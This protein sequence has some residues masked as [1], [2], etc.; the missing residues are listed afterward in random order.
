[1][2]VEAMSESSSKALTLVRRRSAAA[3]P[4]LPIILEYQWPSAAVVNA[5]IPRS[6][7][8]MTW[9]IGSMVAALFT[10]MALIPVDQVVS[11]TGMVV[12]VS[13]TLLV[14]PLETSIVRSIDVREG[15]FVH[16]GDVLAHLDPTFASADY[17]ALA[18]LDTSL[19]AEVA[20]LRAEAGN[21]PFTYSGADPHWQ[22]QEAIYGHRRAEYDLKLDNYRHKLDEL[23]SAISRADADAEGYRE[24]L[25]VAQTI[26]K[27]RK[28]LESE[29]VGSRLNTL[30][31]TDSRAEMTRSLATA[32]KT[33]ESAKREL[34]ALVSERDGFI[35]TWNGDVAQKISDVSQKLN[36]VS[37]QLTKAKL[38]RQLVEL[39][40]ERDATV[41]SVAKVSIGSVLQSGQQLFTL[42][43]E[44]AVLEVEAN[45][46]GHDNGFVHMADPVAIK[47][48][49][50]PYARFGM[51]EG[52]VR[53]ISADSFTAQS[54]A[55]NPTSSLPV[56]TGLTPFYRAHITIDQVKLHNVPKDF[57][58][59]PGMPVTADIKV[60]KRT[61]LGAMFGGLLP[62]A[63]EGLREP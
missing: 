41:L 38:R 15:Q 29:R 7:R 47:F 56:T 51:A 43:P 62:A 10:A 55:R 4:T 35:Q 54:E 33:E 2:G 46:S 53:I 39:R 60:G 32:E 5:P 30:M 17:G 45:I 44:D 13:P 27:M 18:D 59:I 3:D 21:K 22:L 49:T 11:A 1:L 19:E 34:A 52:T 48:D 63:Q 6:A 58:L 42:V 9:V 24:R 16:A 8:G 14:Q 50:F 25:G 40:A 28:D 23:T 12:S 57:H 36:E 31:A 61:M 20:R 26:E 37:E